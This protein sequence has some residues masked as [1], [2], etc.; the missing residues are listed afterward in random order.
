MRDPFR[1]VATATLLLTLV[2]AARSDTI[3]G[4]VVDSFGVGVAGVDIDVKNLGGGGDP[5]PVN[6]GTDALTTS[7][8]PDAF[9]TWAPFWDT[10]GD[11]PGA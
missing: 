3:V 2:P 8:L 10:A 5:D 6:D 11:A 9:P 1:F 7:M 4:Q